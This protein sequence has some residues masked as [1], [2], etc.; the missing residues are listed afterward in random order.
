[1][2]KEIKNANTT[3]EERKELALKFM[4][5]LDIYKPYIKGF[6]NNDEVCFFERFAGYWAWQNEDLENK[7]KELEGKYNCTV[8]AITHEFAEFG[9]LYNF[10]IITDYK[11]EW[12][13]LICKYSTNEF[14]AFSYV[15]NKSDED[16]SEFGTILIQS[17]GGGIRRIS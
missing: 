17:F 5:Q 8:Y 9:E 11:E 13:D 15:W 10:L 7:I 12:D 14:S 16:L 4:K 1:M 2:E 3:K 6:E